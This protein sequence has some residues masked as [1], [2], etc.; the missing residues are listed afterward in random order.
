[1][2]PGEGNAPI[3]AV[4][5][6]HGSAA[7]FRSDVGAQL[8]VNAAIESVRSFAPGV[9]VVHDRDRLRTLAASTLPSTIVERW[10]RAVESD[11]DERPFL[12]NELDRAGNDADGTDPLVAYGTTLLVASVVGG[13]LL[14]VQIGDGDI[15]TVRRGDEAGSLP[16]PS[17]ERL[18]GNV[19]TSLCLSDAVDDFRIEVLDL[20]DEIAPDLVVVTTDGYSNSF[21]DPSAFLQAGPDIL[22]MLGD[23]GVDFVGERLP[24]WLE[25]ASKEG[26]GDDVTLALI[27][28]NRAIAPGVA[29]DLANLA[30][31][32]QSDRG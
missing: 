15:V 13:S 28:R 2:I 12:A 31:T 3:V 27:W 32:R 7:S 11:L 16:V 5:D 6:G 29:A 8:A 10:R 4:A 24:Q 19:T 26:S 30:Q 17:D 23:R 14:L 18:V 20:T 1:M 9:D 21:V 25:R 22:Q